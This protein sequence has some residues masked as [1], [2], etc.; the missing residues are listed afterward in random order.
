MQKRCSLA[1][2]YQKGLNLK[3]FLAV[4]F[5]IHIWIISLISNFSFMNYQ[6]LKIVSFF[7]IRI[8]VPVNS[9]LPVQSLILRILTRPSLLRLKQISK[10]KKIKVI[11]KSQSLN[12][13]K[14]KL[15]PK[16]L[17]FNT[18]TF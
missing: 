5:K 13:L 6:R 1:K 12:K 7:N 15:Y 18:P 16:R 11:L 14:T 3:K 10:K 17:V 2:K 8:L 9:N 4:I